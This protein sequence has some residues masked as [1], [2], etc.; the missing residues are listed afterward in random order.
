MTISGST[1]SRLQQSE[2]GAAGKPDRPDRRHVLL[3]TNTGWSMVRYRGELIGGLLERGWQVSA[4]A[5]FDERQASHL[6][7]RGVAPIRLKVEGLGRNPLRDLGYLRR[8]ASLL[9]ALRPDV[10]HNFSIKP[11]IYGSLAAKLVGLAPEGLNR[12]F[13][14][15]SG[16]TAVEVAVKMAY[17]FWQLSGRPEKRGFVALEHHPYARHLRY[18]RRGRRCGVDAARARGTPDPG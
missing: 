14:S 9:R 12:V 5:D 16:S 3:V 18:R 13:Y 4:V 6:R 7:G 2:A 11:V 8:L 15:D 1:V 10:L 17:Q